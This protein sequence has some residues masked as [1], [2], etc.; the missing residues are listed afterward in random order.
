MSRVLT[1]PGFEN[2]VIPVVRV[3]S[4]HEVNSVRS[5]PRCMHGTEIPTTQLLLE[6]PV[7][8]LILSFRLCRM[9]PG[10]DLYTDI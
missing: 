8:Y 4:I 1:R 2:S 7:C 9:L 6:K 10:E 3:Y 5:T